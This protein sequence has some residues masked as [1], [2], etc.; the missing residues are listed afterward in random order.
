MTTT[1]KRLDLERVAT[2]NGEP[3]IMRDGNGR[4]YWP[5]GSRVTQDH[6]DRLENSEALDAICKREYLTVLGYNGETDEEEEFF[7]FELD[8]PQGKARRILMD[9]GKVYGDDEPD[10]TLLTDFLTDAMH[11]LGSE[12]LQAA[13]D[14]A[15]SHYRTERLEAQ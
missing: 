3:V 15:L 7:G 11:L 1:E 8:S 4:A 14:Q 2:D 12:A 6:C 5:D 13:F 10:E 9:A